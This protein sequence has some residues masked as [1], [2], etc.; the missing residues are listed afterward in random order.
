[1]LL[2]ELTLI[3]WIWSSESPSGA[4]STTLIQSES[5]G[6]YSLSVAWILFGCQNADMSLSWQK[7]IHPIQLCFISLRSLGL[8]LIAWIWHGG[9]HG[10]PILTC[11]IMRHVTLNSVLI[12]NLNLVAWNQFGRLESN[13]SLGTELVAQIQ[14]NL[15]TKS[16]I[17][18]LVQH[19]IY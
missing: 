10:Q 6:I 13:L 8:L 1:M 14:L 4:P 19:M 7:L 18:E 16:C 17:I 12:L 11:H 5:I 15:T 9:Q 2:F 3:V